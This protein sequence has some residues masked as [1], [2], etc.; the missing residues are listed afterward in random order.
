MGNQ[1]P[2]TLKG[3]GSQ[4][5]HRRVLEKKMDEKVFINRVLELVDEAKTQRTG[6]GTTLVKEFNL[7]GKHKATRLVQEHFGCSLSAI[8]KLRFEY[9]EDWKTR[10]PKNAET[11]LELPDLYTRVQELR[12]TIFNF[13]EARDILTKEY[14]LTDMEVVRRVRSVMQKPMSEVFFPTSEE[15]QECLIRANTNEEFKDLL[16]IANHEFGGFYDKHLGVSNFVQA[17]TKCLY[18]LKIPNISPCTADNEAIIISQ[19]LGDGSYDTTRKAI[20]IVHGIRQLTYLRF[21][22]SLINNA[23]PQTK[24]ISNI[25][26]HVH[27][28]GH[29]YCSWYSG[30][31]PEHVHTKI[32]SYSYEQLLEALTPL[33]MFLLFLDDGCLY[34]QQSKVISICQG[35]TLEKHEQFAKLLSTYGIHA[36][37]TETACNIQRQ[38]DIVKFLNTF[39]KPFSHIMPESMRYKTEIMI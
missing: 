23:Y 39:V 10:L 34:W 8:L 19:V 35:R 9:P 37:V 21:K 6:V 20:R 33:G 36:N 32:E 31:L 16:G 14:N 24:P 17:K 28:Q 4:T 29:E 2:S 26:C 13:K 38:V 7:P 3:E 1:Q 27:K 25:S 15:I 18:K 11:R 12:K 30:K 5:K 22:V